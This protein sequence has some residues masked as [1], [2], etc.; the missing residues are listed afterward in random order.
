MA[1]TPTPEILGTELPDGSRFIGTP[2]GAAANWRAG[3]AEPARDDLNTCV[4]CGLCLPHCPTYRLTGEEPQSPRGRIAAMR[5][6]SD[7]LAAPDRT[8]ATFMDAC[9]VCRACEDV[10]PSHV[11]FGRMMEGARE[12]VEI[13]RTRRS[14]FARWIGFH[15]ILPHPS[16][17]RATAALTPVARPFMPR[18]LR[19]LLPRKGHPFARLPKVSEPSAGIEVRG[20]VALLAGCA[21][22]RWYHQVNR[23]TIRVLNR[24]GWRVTVP[25]SQGCCG[26]LAAHNGRLA[27]ARRLAK[28]AAFAFRDADVVIANA[29]GCS[30]H[31]KTY[32]ELLPGTG[33]PVRDLTEFLFDEGMGFALGPLDLTVAYHDAC[34][35]VRA[36]AIRLQPRRLLLEIPELQLVEIPHGDRCCGA[37][38]IHNVTQPEASG[39]LGRAKAEAIAGTGATIVASAN[40]GCSMQLARWL[41][42]GGS[43]VEV[44]HPV[45]LLERSA[46]AAG[47]AA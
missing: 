24:A 19:R 38:G 1:S 29:A 45:E 36:Q 34:H 33:L 35:A 3:R 18:H 16:L 14:R 10:C 30:A 47:P 21:Q 11:P 43:A 9:L 44:V 8:F 28:R 13:T 15:W 32:E 7:G 20:T 25:R 26:A 40:P 31:M 22:D 6:V 17:I 27:I 42:E 37:A 2:D 4:A 39:E 46:A 5:A 23:A 12:Q 41:R